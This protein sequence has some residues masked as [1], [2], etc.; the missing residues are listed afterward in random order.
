MMATNDQT[1]TIAYL[2]MYSAIHYVDNR[3]GPGIWVAMHA[4]DGI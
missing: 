2:I 1:Q 3:H 4:F